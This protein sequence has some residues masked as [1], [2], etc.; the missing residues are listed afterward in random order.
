M[1]KAPVRQRK[2]CARTGANPPI[3]TAMVLVG[4]AIMASNG[5]AVA[6]ESTRITT[7]GPWRRV[8]LLRLTW[9][10]KAV[11]ADMPM[12]M[13]ARTNRGLEP[14]MATMRILALN[15]HRTAYHATR[16]CAGQSARGMLSVGTRPATSTATVAAS[17]FSSK[18]ATITHSMKPATVLRTPWRTDSSSSGCGRSPSQWLPCGMRGPRS[19][20]FQPR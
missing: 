16:V 6:M 12:G 1:A 3:H 4:F 7:G 2:R 17:R 15:A 20:A 19:V 11:C 5:P 14:S 13:P 8:T 10:R 9:P 18:S